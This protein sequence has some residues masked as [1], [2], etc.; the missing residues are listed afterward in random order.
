MTATAPAHRDAGPTE[1]AAA[2]RAS[3]W[4]DSLE[5]RALRAT[6]EAGDHGLTA[7]E[8]LDVLGLPITKLYSAAPRFSA[9]KRKGWVESTDAARENFGVYVATAAGRAKAGAA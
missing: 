6:V 7:L 2:K 3:K 4:A 9:M 8:S 5:A 1:V